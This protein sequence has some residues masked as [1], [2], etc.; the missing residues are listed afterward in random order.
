MVTY[1]CTAVENHT[2]VDGEIGFLVLIKSKKDG[3]GG[4]VSQ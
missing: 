1:L 3:E 2:D 4:A